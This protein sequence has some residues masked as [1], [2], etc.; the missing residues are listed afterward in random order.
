MAPRRT[1]EPGDLVTPTQAARMLAVNPVTVRSWIHRYGL[2]P[3]GNLGRWP[4][5]DFNEI[6]TVEAALRRSE[7]A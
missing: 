3:L 1:L 4:A 2:E 6:A 5:Y 7:A